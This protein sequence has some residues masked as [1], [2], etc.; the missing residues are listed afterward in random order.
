MSLFNYSHASKKIATTRRRGLDDTQK[1]RM[2]CVP[3]AGNDPRGGKEN[4][5]TERTF[6]LTWGYRDGGCA[7]SGH[8]AF[9]RDPTGDSELTRDEALTLAA[10][11]QISRPDVQDMQLWDW[12]DGENPVLVCHQ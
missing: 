7:D 8:I 6:F 2:L 5:M 10:I 9:H 11:V 3:L 1:L 12:A 4:T